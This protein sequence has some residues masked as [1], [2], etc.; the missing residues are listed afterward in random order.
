[1]WQL[2]VLS[3]FLT[4]IVLLARWGHYY[5]L[6]GSWIVYLLI[7]VD[8]AD[9]EADLT[10]NPFP[11]MANEELYV[12]DPKKTAWLVWARRIWLAIWCWIERI[13]TVP[14]QSW[15][16][17]IC[18]LSFNR[19][20]GECLSVCLSVQ[21]FHLQDYLLDFTAFWYYGMITKRRWAD[22]F[23]YINIDPYFTWVS[24]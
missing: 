7:V 10:E 6:A 21:K 16:C 3:G 5:D 14:M 22:Y 15:V 23:R 17:A 12:D 24:R 9:E 19:V 2:F 8:D 1:M 4:C 20:C 11:A 18:M 13:W